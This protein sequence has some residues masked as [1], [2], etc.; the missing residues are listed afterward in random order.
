MKIGVP[1]EIKPQEKRVGL[2]PESVAALVGDGHKVTVQAGAGA[3]IGADDATYLGAGASIETDRDAIFFGSEMIVK[4]KEP[5]QEEIALLRENQLL[6]TYLHLAPDRPQTEGL[7]NSRCTAI[8]YETITDKSGALPLLRPMSQ[9]AGR[10]SVHVAATTLQHT[11]GGQGLLLGGVPGVGPAKVLILGGGVSGRHAAQMAVGMGADVTVF[12]LNVSVLEQLDVQFGTSL[13]TQFST[14]AALR[15]ALETADVVIGAVLVAGAKAPKLLTADDLKTMKPGAVLVDIAIDQG[16]C[17]ETS[18]PTT[19]ENPTYV[20]DD[21]V[22][23][24]V[25][26]MPGGVPKTSTYALNAATL[27]FA[28]ALA[29]KGW[30][31]ACESDPHLALGLNVH[32]GKIKHPEVAHAFPDLAADL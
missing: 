10:M 4:V 9:V 22:H 28:R 26:N 15:S 11:N 6:F 32:K 27:P 16:G 3:G 14:R 29:N 1:S 20:V 30:E 2:T 12:D 17:F 8:A 18:K 31:A 24:C 21:V 13:K 5:Q 7:L 23:Y 25:A 19:H